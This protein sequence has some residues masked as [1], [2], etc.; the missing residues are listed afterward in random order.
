MKYEAVKAEILKQGLSKDGAMWK[1]R[2]GVLDRDG[3]ES[4][5]SAVRRLK[6]MVDDGVS[7]ERVLY[8]TLFQAPYEIENT[9]AHYNRQDPELG[10][11]I[12]QI[13]GRLSSAISDLL[14]TGLESYYKD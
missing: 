13:S 7:V 3:F 5:I 10:K 4:L 6:G 12:I 8:A 11:A 1:I 9:F 14:W 2:E